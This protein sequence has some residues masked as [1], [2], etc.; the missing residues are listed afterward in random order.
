MLCRASALCALLAAYGLMILV[1]CR[2]KPALTD[3]QAEGKHLYNDGC[4]HCHEQ[5][6]LHLKKVPRIYMAYLPRT[7]YLVA[8]PQRMLKLSIS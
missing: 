6:D 5:N 7:N 2:T 1:G 4:A 3:E 8:N